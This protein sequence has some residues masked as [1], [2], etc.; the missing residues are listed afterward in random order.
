MAIADVLS[1]VK[2]VGST[3]Y[4]PKSCNINLS[5]IAYVLASETLMYSDFAVE[6]ATFLPHRSPG[7]CSTAKSKCIPK[8]DFMSSSSSL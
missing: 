5:Q 8:V 6:S 3:S 2:G 1:H 7:K 4:S